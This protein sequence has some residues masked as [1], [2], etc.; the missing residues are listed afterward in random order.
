MDTQPTDCC[1]LQSSSLKTVIVHTNLC[2]VN[3][4]KGRAVKLITLKSL[5]TPA[6]LAT[7]DPKV[8]YSFCKDE[9]CEVVYFGGADRYTVQDLKVKVHQKDNGSDVPACYCFEWTPKRIAEAASRGEADQIAP[10]IS[11]HIKAGRCGC[12]VNNPQGSCC[13]GN[14]NALVKKIVTAK[15]VL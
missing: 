11:G 9:T 10:S 8:E 13:L 3:G 4:T 5:L 2:P 14:V 6:A 7:L 12:E 1:S 15:P